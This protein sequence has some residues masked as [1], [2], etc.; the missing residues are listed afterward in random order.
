MTAFSGSKP[1]DMDLVALSSALL[2]AACEGRAMTS[3]GSNVR[4]GVATTRSALPAS[5][6]LIA[7]AGPTVFSSD[8]VPCD[9]FQQSCLPTTSALR[10]PASQRLAVQF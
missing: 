1:N 4:F 10:P 9:D 3:A 5:R 7:V 2:R 8:R 6:S